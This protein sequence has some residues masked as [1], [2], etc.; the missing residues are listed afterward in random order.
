MLPKSNDFSSRDF[1][2]RKMGASCGLIPPNVPSFREATEKM[3]GG[4]MKR[5]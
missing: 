1:G 3:K 2:E 4:F 5:I